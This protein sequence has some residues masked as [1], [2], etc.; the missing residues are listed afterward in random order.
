MHACTA[1]GLT[2][3]HLLLGFLDAANARREDLSMHDVAALLTWLARARDE[4][5]RLTR[6]RRGRVRIARL[7]RPAVRALREADKQLG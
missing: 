2:N 3:E 4:V 6:S 5:P 7:M 1:L